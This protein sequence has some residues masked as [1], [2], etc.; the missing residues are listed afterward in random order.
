MLNT[1]VNI[2]WDG[3]PVRLTRGTI[4]D[5]PAGGP[6]ETAIGTSNLVSLSGQDVG[7]DPAGGQPETEG[8]S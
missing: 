2:T 7:G 5:I 1:T 8:V 6:L 3:V 4:I